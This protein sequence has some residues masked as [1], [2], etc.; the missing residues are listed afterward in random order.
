MAL[1]ASPE[2]GANILKD[3]TAWVERSEYW[4]TYEPVRQGRR[5]KYRYR[6]PLILCG[7]LSK[8]LVKYSHYQVR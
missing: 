6:E 8:T 7:Q 1:R 3:D 4:R 2:L 5:K